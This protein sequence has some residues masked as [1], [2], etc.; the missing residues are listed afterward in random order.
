MVAAWIK[1]AERKRTKTKL[2]N[3]LRIFLSYIAVFK[4]SEV[5]VKSF[6]P[7]NYRYVPIVTQQVARSSRGNVRRH[8]ANGYRVFRGCRRIQVQG[9]YAPLSRF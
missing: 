6:S 2:N 8:I 9:D 7:D 5:S 4:H 3:T 1:A